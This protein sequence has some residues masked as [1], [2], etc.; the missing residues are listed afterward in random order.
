[1][2]K[3]RNFPYT[4]TLAIIQKPHRKEM[5]NYP[6]TIILLALICFGC[7]QTKECDLLI[8]NA[9]VLDVET[10][11]ILQ[12]KTLIVTNGIIQNILDEPT[13]Y[14][15]IESIDAK[16]KLVTPS[17]IDTHIHP[18]DVFGD[19]EKAPKSLNDNSRKK[20]SN[21]YLPFGTTTTLMI[22]QPEDW[23]DTILYWQKNQNS[24]FVDVFTT[25]GAI[26]SKENREPYIGHSVVANSSE[27]KAKVIEYY[28][29]GIN[30]I[31]LYYRL[32]N[33]EFQSAFETADSLNM[34][35]YGHI[36][37][38]NLENQ[39]IDKTLSIGLK[40]YEHL[41]IIPNSV[42]SEKEDWD[43]VNK[44]FSEKFGELNSESRVI[45]Y[46]L[47][48]FRYAEIH[49][50]DELNKFIEQLSIEKVSF[51]TTLHFLYQQFGETYFTKPLD[52]TL[53][54][55]QTERCF[56][57]F[58]ILMQNTKKMYDKGVEI[59]LGSDMVNGGKANL[60][61]LILLCEYGFSVNDAFKIASLNG[62]KAIGIENEVGTLK[63]GRKA[64]LIIW[65]KSPFD[66]IKNFTSEK[67]IIKGG[68]QLHRNSTIANNVYN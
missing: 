11:E 20:L 22:G 5:R 12:N 2:L 58:K 53:T 13:D 66:D 1:M 42:L 46:L 62:A 24:N 33:P 16:G 54:K 45:E 31:K 64:N 28:N 4:N 34:N 36:G 63:K 48:L 47:E 61:E 52:T 49:K 10:G 40:N 38:F 17:F 9:N 32:N 56:E 23:L 57:N 67:I 51:S 44:L 30:H 29:R 41:G 43:I 39:T 25:G 21:E 7:K 59:R 6:I 60:S 65:E 14:E 55:E 35:I 68:K 26:I 19:R 37:G 27:A 8:E 15:G 18:T 3:I 50:K